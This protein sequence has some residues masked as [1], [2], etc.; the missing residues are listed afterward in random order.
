MNRRAA[1]QARL[2]WWAAVAVAALLCGL[3]GWSCVR[4]AGDGTRA[5]AEERD[6]VLAAGRDHVARLS[7]VDA[8]DPGAA[9]AR[10]LD[11]TTGD[12]HA[13]L[14]GTDPRKGTGGASTRATVTDA[15]LTA[16]DDR[17]GTAELIA[18]VSVE[19]TPAAGRPGGTDRKRLEAALVR[20]GGGWKVTAL[21]AVPVGGS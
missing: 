13:R 10:W 16:L 19:T 15:A 5:F 12:L 8:A 11:A 6:D 7:S 18:T 3:A 1:G 17:A 2:G 14:K 21:T 20:T 4:A 9:R